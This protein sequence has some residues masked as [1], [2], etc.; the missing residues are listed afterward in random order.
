MQQVNLNL[1]KTQDELI[2]LEKMAAMGRAVA[3]IAHELNTPICIA[4]SAAE[5]IDTQTKMFLGRLETAKQEDTKAS[6]TQCNKDLEKLSE[7]LMSGVSRAAELVRNFKEISNDQT[8]IQK[9]SFEL[10]Q[11]MKGSMGVLK[12]SL[13]RQNITVNF[14]GNEIVLY[15]DAGLFHQIIENLTTNVQKYAYNNEGGHI[16]ITLKDAPNEI[17]LLFTDY[18]KGI[19]EENLS[20]I[21]DAFFTTG[22]GKGGTGLG[23]N[24]VYRIVTTQLKGT[25]TCNSN[26]ERVLYSH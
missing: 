11:Y 24:I 21:F 19:P 1:E 10:L 12:N 4:R 20:K 15:S 22:G 2:K 16:D 9:K 13:K 3:R 26:G 23:L 14:H 17:T 25:I 7:I 8:N 6:V 5:N 18:G